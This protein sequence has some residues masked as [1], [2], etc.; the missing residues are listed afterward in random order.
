MSRNSL[1]PEVG[2]DRPQLA[3]SPGGPHVTEDTG[4]SNTGPEDLGPLLNLPA[5]VLWNG[6]DLF[7]CSDGDWPASL[8]SSFVFFFFFL[9]RRA[10]LAGEHAVNCP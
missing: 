6:V 10:E 3:L 4:R 1:S 2:C 7:D 9:S 5:E 8:L